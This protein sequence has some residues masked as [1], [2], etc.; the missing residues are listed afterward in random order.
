MIKFSDVLWT[1]LQQK[2]HS[3]KIVKTVNDGDVMTFCDQKAENI[4]K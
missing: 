3:T 4:M 2:F 1:G